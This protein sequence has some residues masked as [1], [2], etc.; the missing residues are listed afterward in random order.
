MEF[1]TWCLGWGP[2]GGG[3]KESPTKSVVPRVAEVELTRTR[4][5]LRFQTL[6]KNWKK[7]PSS[8]GAANNVNGLLIFSSCN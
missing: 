4:P 1:G 6:K 3:R 7:K 2:W 8:V 5:H